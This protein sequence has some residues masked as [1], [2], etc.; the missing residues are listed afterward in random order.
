MYLQSSWLERCMAMHVKS[1]A[2]LCVSFACLASL[3]LWT[4]QFVFIT[5]CVFSL[6]M[7]DGR[8]EVH[9]RRQWEC[10]LSGVWCE[11]LERGN[12]LFYIFTPTLHVKRHSWSNI[13]SGMNHLITFW[14]EDSFWINSTQYFIWRCSI[15]LN[16][17][18]ALALS[19]ALTIFWK[20][21]LCYILFS[22]LIKRV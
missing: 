12:F 18:E 1:R 7:S 15:I 9:F 14:L 10:F 2:A 13:Q 16:L 11:F 17:Q 5:N 3:Y 21:I 4:S 22:K 6:E 19:D 8:L 20:I